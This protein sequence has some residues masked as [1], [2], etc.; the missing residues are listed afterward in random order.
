METHDSSTVLGSDL[1]TSCS[2]DSILTH[3][4]SSFNTTSVRIN[5]RQWL[6]C[7]EV[8]CDKNEDLKCENH[9]IGC[10]LPCLVTPI[11]RQH[12]HWLASHSLRALWF[13][14]TATT[15]PLS[16]GTP[17]TPL[18]GVHPPP[19]LAI[20]QTWHQLWLRTPACSLKWN[21]NV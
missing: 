18:V 15:A 9:W 16:R 6:T 5:F 17:A 1:T 21:Y 4:C 3:N 10:T 12:A 13:D 11:T 7:C 14:W 2:E 8:G 19:P 20:I